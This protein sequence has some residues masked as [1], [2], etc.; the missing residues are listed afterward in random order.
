MSNFK[1]KTTAAFER[2][3]KQAE[4]VIGDRKEVDRLLRRAFEKARRSQGM[5]H[6]VW[7]DLQLLFRMIKA[8]VKGDYTSVPWRT[9]VFGVALLLYFLNPIDIIP[10]FIP[11][12]GFLDDVALAI[13]VFN[14]I[15]SDLKTFEKWEESQQIKI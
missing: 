12:I 4:K 15:R 1:E 11:F 9:L 5:L 3:K 6:R 7:D 10:D 13:I 14:S 8:W 2:A